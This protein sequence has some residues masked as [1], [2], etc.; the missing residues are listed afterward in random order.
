M[1]PSQANLVAIELALRGRAADQRLHGDAAANDGDLGPVAAGRVV[2][3]VRQV[4]R[5]GAGPVLRDDGRVAGR[6]LP[7]CR[8][9][10]RP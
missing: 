8:A 6:Y 1:L 9:S 3:I 2:E 4:E 7:I 5:A 10:S